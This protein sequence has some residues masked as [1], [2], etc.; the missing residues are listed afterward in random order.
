MS[1]TYNNDDEINVNKK[2]EFHAK[3]GES[4]RRVV[5]CLDLL[6]K[7]NQLHVTNGNLAKN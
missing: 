3:H 5:F 7:D 6:D 1:S 2:I 4:D